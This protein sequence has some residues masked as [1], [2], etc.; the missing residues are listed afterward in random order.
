MDRKQDGEKYAAP[1]SD[2]PGSAKIFVESLNA[3]HEIFVFDGV[4]SNPVTV[5]VAYRVV[6]GRAADF[7]S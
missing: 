3:M 2:V 7:H 5:T 6:S 1:K 4:T